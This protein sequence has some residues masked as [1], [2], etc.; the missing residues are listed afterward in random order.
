MRKHG[1]FLFYLQFSEEAILR[2][3]FLRLWDDY[4]SGERDALLDL[5]RL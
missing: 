1:V 4:L 2:M 3:A 5:L